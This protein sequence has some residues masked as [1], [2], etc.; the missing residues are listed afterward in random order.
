MKMIKNIILFLVSFII[1]AL[2]VEIY[3]VNSKIVMPAITDWKPEGVGLKPNTTIVHFADGFGI[4]ETDNNGIFKTNFGSIENKK[5]IRIALIGDSYVRG[6]HIFPREHFATKMIQKLENKYPNTGFEVLNFGRIGYNLNDYY[7]TYKN[8]VEK[9]NPDFTFMFVFTQDFW[10]FNRNRF[11]PFVE[12]KEGK[13]VIN[14]SFA[15]LPA[16]KN[17]IKTKKYRGIS[18]LAAMLKKGKT[19]FDYKRDLFDGLFSSD[20]IVKHS[21]STKYVEMYDDLLRKIE[22]EDII[23]VSTNRTGDFYKNKLKQAKLDYID[24]ANALN[25]VKD[26]DKE[27]HYW[28]AT[29]MY[30][31]WN[32]KAH[33]KIG[34][35]LAKQMLKRIEQGQKIATKK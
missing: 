34:E 7:C 22:Q 11:R 2:F 35:Y 29:N 14:N 25:D 30:G 26:I 12:K 16:Y 18:V 3:L 9:Y 13:L 8:E 17:R 6:E 32:H 1:I 21:D 15:N 27:Y 23:V 10:D 19:D 20:I 31:H 5:T 28:K 33:K 24:V 4:S